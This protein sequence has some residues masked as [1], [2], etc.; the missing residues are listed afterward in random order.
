[1]NDSRRWK[2]FAYNPVGGKILNFVDG[3][4]DRYPEN[5]IIRRVWLFCLPF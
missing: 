2:F 1:M 4:H 5:K 3:L